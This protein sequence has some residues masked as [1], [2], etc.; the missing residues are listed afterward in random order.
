MTTALLPEMIYVCE[1]CSHSWSERRPDGDDP[2]NCENCGHR[3]LRVFPLRIVGNDEAAEEYAAMV[4]D[5]V[6]E[7]RS[8]VTFDFDSARG[9]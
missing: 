9:A 1:S 3:Y 5:A 4:Y 7:R 6:Q 2:M 8:R